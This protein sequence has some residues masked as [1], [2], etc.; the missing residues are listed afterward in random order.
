[1][2]AVPSFT[3]TMFDE[4][5]WRTILT[6]F[7]L[8][9]R[10]RDRSI[11]CHPMTNGLMASNTKQIKSVVPHWNK[12]DRSYTTANQRFYINTAQLNR[13]IAF[14]RWTLFVV[15][16][17]HTMYDVGSATAFNLE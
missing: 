10:A 4:P 8:T 2:A 6:N 11:K 13:I 17:I 16:D 5:I 7:E 1:M 12:P 15:K 14:Y 3:D 9:T